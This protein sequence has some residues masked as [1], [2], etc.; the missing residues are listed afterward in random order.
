MK[1][2]YRYAGL[3]LAASLLLPTV[4]CNKN[5]SETETEKATSETIAD[6]TET[7]LEE[8][9]EQ[10]TELTTSEQTSASAETTTQDPD[11]QLD[12]AADLY[13]YYASPSYLFPE[14]VGVAN[15]SPGETGYEFQLAMNFGEC[16]CTALYK[17]TAT[18]EEHEFKLKISPLERANDYSFKTTVLEYTGDAAEDFGDFKD[19]AKTPFYKFSVGDELFIYMPNTPK[20]DLPEGAWH[21][22]FGNDYGGPIEE[23]D[24]LQYFIMYNSTTEK[25]Y[26]I[27]LTPIAVTEKTS[28]EEMKNWYGEYINTIEGE[29]LKIYEDPS[30]G[31]PRLDCKFFNG[32]WCKNMSVRKVVGDPN[33]IYAY[34]ETEK[35]IFMIVGVEIGYDDALYLRIHEYESPDATLYDR[36]SL[37]EKMYVRFEKKS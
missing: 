1:R 29:E 21:G 12:L 24:R 23:D 19:F 36:D 7:S 2:I 11:P 15:E 3:V 28:S 9:T 25:S 18:G 13:N 10:T 26:N 5:S 35:G 31:E 16:R 6:T 14:W 27:R 8:T 37:N 32:E 20:A 17:I 30:S 22:Y 34:G 4:G 33:W